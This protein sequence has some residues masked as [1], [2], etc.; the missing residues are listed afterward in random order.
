MLGLAAR[1]RLCS[2][3]FSLREDLKLLSRSMA[4]GLLIWFCFGFSLGVLFCRCCVIHHHVYWWH[5]W[6]FL[7]NKVASMSSYSSL[8]GMNRLLLSQS[9]SLGPS[10]PHAL[11]WAWTYWPDEQQ[12]WFCRQ[13]IKGQMEHSGP[14]ASA[15]AKWWSSRFCWTMVLAR[16]R[17]R[18][19]FLHHQ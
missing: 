4:K 12:G 1:S 11:L 5:A 3:F 2:T 6:T 19:S 10:I 17:N 14:V 16:D 15:S 9:P 8:S 18:S 13:P 7:T